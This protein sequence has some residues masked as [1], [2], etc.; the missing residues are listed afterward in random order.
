MSFNYEN[1]LQVVESSDGEFVDH[2]KNDPSRLNV[3]ISE[4]EKLCVTCED[5]TRTSKW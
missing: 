2:L 5:I 4:V 1:L 3:S